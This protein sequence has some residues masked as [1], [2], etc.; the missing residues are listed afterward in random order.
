[1][2]FTRQGRLIALI[3]VKLGRADG[4]LRLAVQNF[5]FIATGVLNY[6]QDA[7]KW[8]FRDKVTKEH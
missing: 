2:F 8:R 3:Q 6:R 4:H 5:T 7:A 1:M